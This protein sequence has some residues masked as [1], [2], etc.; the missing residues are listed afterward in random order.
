MVTTQTL[1]LPFTVPNRSSAYVNVSVSR[2][3]DPKRYGFSLLFPNHRLSDFVGFPV[4]HAT[5]HSPGSRGYASMYGWIQI[6]RA[7]NDREAAESS[8]WEMDPVPMIADLKTPFCWFGAEPKLFDAPAREGVREID[9]TARSF[10][11]YIEDG[12]MS[13]VVHPILAFEWG[14]DIHDGEKSI[15]PLQQLGAAPWNEHLALFAD[16]YPDWRFVRSN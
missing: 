6:T 1:H 2:N 15:K 14:F 12:L 10:L 16:Q 8:A 3:D 7:A 13:K 11:T 4:C 5:V 9:W